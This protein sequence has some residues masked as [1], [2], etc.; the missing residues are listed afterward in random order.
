MRKMFNVYVLR[1][2]KNNKR[3]IGCIGK[4][5]ETRTQEHNSSTDDWTRHNKPFDLLHSEQFE[6]K[7]DA[8][9]REKFFK[10]GQGRK[11]LDTIFPPSW[12]FPPEADQP[13]AEVEQ[14]QPEADQPS[15]G[16]VHKGA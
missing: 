6:T 9:R 11:L 4:S 5:P 3:Y 13:S 16:A 15:A 2:R 10:S 7:A 14:V 12:Q 8:L 1:S